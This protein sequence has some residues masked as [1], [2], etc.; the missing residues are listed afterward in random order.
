MTA[1]ETMAN[2]V[3]K[4]GAYHNDQPVLGTAES[5]DQ[6][7]R[8]AFAK[9]LAKVLVQSP[10]DDCLTVSLEGEWGYGK[11]SV[12][13]L[14]KKHCRELS[15]DLIV[16]EY[17]PWISGKADAL[18]QDFLVQF[19]S[20]LNIPNR[21]KE[22]IKAAQ[23]VLAYSKLFSVVKLIPGVEPWASIVEG[24]FKATGTAAKKIGS[25]KELDLLARKKKVQEA[26]YKLKK[27]ILVLIDDIDR[28]PPDEAFQVVRLIKAV[29]DFRG[30]SFLL[31]FDPGYLA[32]ALERQGIGNSQ[33]YVDKV[34][35]VRVPL[36]LIAQQDMHRLAESELARLA[37][38]PLTAYFKKDQERFGLLYHRYVK[39][40]VRSP[41]ELKRTFNHLR[42]LL[43]QTE[44]MVCFSDLFGLAVLAIRSP[45]VYQHIKEIP[46]AY[47]GRNFDEQLEMEEPV[48][49]VQRHKAAREKVFDACLGK[50]RVFVEGIVKEMF[51]LVEPNGFGGSED[52]YDEFGRVASPKRLYVALHYQIPTGYAADPDVVAFLTGKSDRTSYLQRALREDFVERFF[53][54]VIQNVDKVPQ[55]Q[56]LP[57]LRALYDVMLP[58]EYLVNQENGLLGFFGFHLFQTLRWV[59]FDLIKRSDNKRDLIRQLANT[60]GYVFI[61]ADILYVLMSQHGEVK[62]AGGAEVEGKWLDESDYEDVKSIWVHTAVNAMKQ[63]RYLNSVLAS[64]VFFQLKRLDVAKTRE[65]LASLMARDNGLEAVAKLIGRS[66]S[67]S[68]NGPYSEISRAELEKV[69]DFEVFAAEAKKELQRNKKLPAEIRA[70]YLSVTTGDKYYLKDALKGEKF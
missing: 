59:T 8:T 50:D 46:A 14:V 43:T 41:R 55:E 21:P 17:N 13:N 58:S 27:P 2:K 7:N 10:Q 63:E 49:I 4:I 19:S 40:L 26:L 48:K 60:A 66:G 65:L 20:Q 31:A 45:K 16:V 32:S 5:P 23:E 33:Q 11:T 25:L 70:T 53:E 34:V 52:R 39:Y 57:A 64:H 67:D 47:V 18:I 9:H 12:I 38:T 36:P 28:L 42:F 6:L 24:V 3:K 51:P 69:L 29:A 1:V 22:A 62:T 30:T 44:A 54:L 35:Q 68:T 61:T 37:E 15:K 56:I